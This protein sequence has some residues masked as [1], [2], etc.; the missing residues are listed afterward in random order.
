MD[1]FIGN[2]RIQGRPLFYIVRL[3]KNGRDYY[4]TND[5]GQGYLQS[6]SR[7]LGNKAFDEARFSNIRKYIFLTLAKSIDEC[8]TLI[9]EY[10]SESAPTLQMS[11][12]NIDI[13]DYD[14]QSAPYALRP[15]IGVITDTHDDVEYTKAAIDLFNEQRCS[16]VIHCGDIVTTSTLELFS[17]LKAGIKLFWINGI[18]HDNQA[19]NFYDLC[20]TS[21]RIGAT[22]LS[23]EGLGIGELLIDFQH[24]KIRIGLCHDTYQKD[25]VIGLDG[26]HNII[27]SWCG[28]RSL[29]YLLFGH[30]HYFNIK[31]PSPESPTVVFN[32]GG[33]HSDILKTIGILDFCNREI[34]LFYATGHSM[35][36]N[37]GMTFNL[38][39]N[40]VRIDAANGREIQELM[41]RE[42]IRNPKYWNDY[43]HTNDS[44]SW[45]LMQ[46]K[47]SSEESSQPAIGQ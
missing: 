2:T 15:R 41:S 16:C 19:D 12:N 8:A 40:E 6:I 24:T 7:Q 14:R 23:R 21:E 46:R 39:T 38:K 20:K 44:H 47:W 9:K 10:S 31:M 36:S 29:D 3:Y 43:F 30:L 5:E 1:Y 37:K 27:W 28:C 26:R 45:P 42:Q 17:A 11:Q 33:L 22:C 32:S 34:D 35:F 25:D 18:R 4:A 13:L